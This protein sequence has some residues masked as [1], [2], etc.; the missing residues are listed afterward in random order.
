MR[1]FEDG[2]WRW[3][4]F[5]RIRDEILCQNI[6]FYWGI[7]FGEKVEERGNIESLKLC[8]FWGYFVDNLENTLENIMVLTKMDW[9][10]LRNL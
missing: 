10:R 5:V 4:K 6:R 8:T 3:G 7:V 2:Y 9:P 1:Y